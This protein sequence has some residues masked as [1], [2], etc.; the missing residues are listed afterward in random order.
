AHAD[1]GRA[2]AGVPRRDRTAG[3]HAD[4]ADQEHH[5]GGHD[6][7]RRG[8]LPD[9][10]HDRVRL[11]E[12]VLDLPD[13]GGRVR[14]PDPAARRLLHL[15]VPTT[16]GAAM[17]SAPT[18]LFDAPGPKARVRHRILS[19]VALLLVLA[20]LALVVVAMANPDNN[21]FAP[22]KWY[23]FLL[24]STWTS[25]LVPGLGFTLASAL[26]AV[27]LSILAGVLLGLGRL[28]PNVAVRAV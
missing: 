10:C 2:A 11:L 24:R 12:A 4:R 21:Q 26:T 8:R 5:R 17:S 3:Q 16:G 13:H 27:V 15:D 22:E 20:V 19:V 7:R 9:A 14:H 6:R 18:V 28:V 23:P 25:Y 1:L